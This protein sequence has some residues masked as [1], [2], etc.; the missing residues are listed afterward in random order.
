LN[1]KILLA[2][3]KDKRFENTELE[4]D[5][6][7]Q[8]VDVARR[9]MRVVWI[10]VII[11]VLALVVRDF[12]TSPK[13]SLGD[14]TT[15]LR[16]IIVA[17]TLM[18][19]WLSDLPK[20]RTPRF[21]KMACDAWT[22]IVIAFVFAIA[23]SRQVDSIQDYY[24]TIISFLVT[25][26]VVGVFY[27]QSFR[28]IAVIF[29]LSW[30]L[31]A[32]IYWPLAK[33]NLEP[34]LSGQIAVCAM[35]V[36]AG[37]LTS[38]IENIERESFL[39]MRDNEKQKDQ[40][41]SESKRKTEFLAALS[42]DL[43]QPLTG[44]VGYLD[45]AKRITDRNGS[46]EV[47]KYIDHAQKGA[48][49][50]QTNLT[51]VLELARLEDIH[52]RISYQPVS[53]NQTFKL[54]GEMFEAK[55]YIDQIRLKII[56]VAEPGIYV[57]SEPDLL[58]QILQ[59]L[60]ANS[61]AYRRNGI[62]N[63]WVLLTSIQVNKNR[64]R[65][66]VVDNGIGI[67]QEQIKQV[68]QPFYQLNNE[69]R[70]AAK[71]VGL[72]LTFVERAVQQLKNH[73]LTV[74]SNGSTFTK[75]SLYLPSTS[76]PMQREEANSSANSRSV[77]AIKE[78]SLKN[79]HVLVIEDDEEIRRMITH[80]LQ[81]AGAT[82]CSITGIK[83]FRDEEANGRILRPALILTDQSLEGPLTGVELVKV[84]REKFEAYIPAILITAI[85]DIPLDAKKSI[86]EIIRKPFQLSGLQKAI[87]N[88]LTDPK[89]ST[90][91]PENY[92]GQ[93]MKQM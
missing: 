9:Y 26:P 59:N 37:S 34:Y 90:E 43:R 92:K 69:S 13:G 24:R 38:I 42:H 45:L 62:S 78:N 49:A 10:P 25:I 89:D 47:A 22:I 64:I 72:G 84:T 19:L 3:S 85:T 91:T 44:L 50:I 15:V 8:N 61:I 17:V 93:Q 60:I 7:M 54:L 5:F 21:T 77:S 58:F 75:F 57:Q 48:S 6:Q 74:H 32:I 65:I 67:P 70:N 27:R 88:V 83:Q 30:T 68:F 53:L 23:L 55:A 33:T 41:A 86:D 51:R 1:T 35:T 2:W 80:Y 4:L 11:S 81:T 82:T 31:L 76:Q 36:L 20:F 28:Q 16:V 71:G 73:E 40:I 46:P 39:A 14:F 29:G 56:V 79:L 18:I 52:K 12:L 87:S 66:T 63:S